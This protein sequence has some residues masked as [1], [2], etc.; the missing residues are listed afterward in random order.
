MAKKTDNAVVMTPAEELAALKAERV[1]LE[2][3]IKGIIAS[4]KDAQVQKKDLQGRIAALHGSIVESNK[5][6][7]VEKAEAK[8]A[9]LQ[10][11]LASLSGTNA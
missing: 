7:K 5:T 6:S 2:G 3:N 8:I 10:A 9:A 11:Q 4:Y 1:A